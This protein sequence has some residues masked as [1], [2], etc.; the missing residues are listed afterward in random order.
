MHVPAETETGIPV[1]PDVETEGI[2]A[3]AVDTSAVDNAELTAGIPILSETIEDGTGLIEARRLEKTFPS[4]DGIRNLNLSVPAGTIFG[5]IGPSGSGKTTT[6]KMFTGSVVPTSGRVKVLGQNPTQFSTATRTRIGYMPQLSVLYPGLTV[7]ENLRFLAALYSHRNQA[8]LDRAL[9]FVELDS[10]RDK[11]ADR[12]SGGMQRRL[13]LAGALAH[14]PELMFL[15][16]PTAGIDPVLRRKFW[17]HFT[18]LKGDGRTLVVTTQYVGEAAYCDFIGVLAD[19]ELLT[20][21]TPEGLRRAAYGGDL[22]DVEFVMRPSSETLDEVVKMLGA[23]SLT[24]TS[25]MSV[26]LVV[27]DAAIAI[28]DLGSWSN[29]REIEIESVEQHVPPFDD[30]F[31]E[32]VE[33]YRSTN[34]HAESTPGTPDKKGRGE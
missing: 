11:R 9:E 8:S 32:I 33:R 31:V 12:I 34:G 7:E 4:G 1:F 20:I 2:E 26:R 14:D 16:E 23:S 22:L 10:H 15:D 30:V 3:S 17:D 28:P 27:P 18:D 29:D 6:V 21:E 19:G 13:S 25:T 5:F 24:K